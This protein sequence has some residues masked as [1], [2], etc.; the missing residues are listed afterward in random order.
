MMLI[1]ERQ[2]RSMIRLVLKE[3]TG[4]ENGLQFKMI[5]DGSMLKKFPNGPANILGK[6][7]DT[8]VANHLADLLSESVKKE[9]EYKEQ[10]NDFKL[11]IYD[12]KVHL[13]NQGSSEGVNLSFAEHS[14]PK[15]GKFWNPVKEK[16]ESGD[17][18][19]IVFSIPY[20][21][22]GKRRLTSEPLL[23]KLKTYKFIKDYNLTLVQP[24]AKQSEPSR[25]KTLPGGWGP[26]K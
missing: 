23:P 21:A 13:P 25:T 19:E 17:T 11:D 18:V 20:S 2:L 7:K 15:Y 1:T 16:L 24:S 26:S 6:W 3:S 22:E 4:S 14:N 8:R 12:W 10:R 9:G 5:F